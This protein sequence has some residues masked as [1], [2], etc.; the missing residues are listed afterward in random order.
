MIVE[1]FIAQLKKAPVLDIVGFFISAAYV[2]FAGLNKK[3][4]WLFAFLGSA[5]Y[6]FLF[7]DNYLYIDAILQVF[8]LVMAIVGW[9]EWERPKSEIFISEWP[10]K[11]HL[12]LLV[13]GSSSTLILGYVFENFTKQVYPYTDAGIF[14]FSIIATYLTTIKIKSTWLYFLVI[15][16]VAVPVYYSRGLVFTTF[17]FVLYVFLA[18]FAYFAW[19][20][21]EKQEARF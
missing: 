17:L 16:A 10:L 13:I 4:C 11:R 2:I 7:F 20:K 9:I 12:I 14:S 3:I 5:M 6:T 15:D 18:L 19:V 8:Y 21:L 1:D